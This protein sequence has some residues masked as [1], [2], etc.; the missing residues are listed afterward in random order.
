MYY[1]SS[2][3]HSVWKVFC[4]LIEGQEREGLQRFGGV[5][6]GIGARCETRWAGRGDRRHTMLSSPRHTGL[7][8]NWFSGSEKEQVIGLGGGGKLVP[9]ITT[10][11]PMLQME[12]TCFYNFNLNCQFIS[13]GIRRLFLATTPTLRADSLSPIFCSIT[14]HKATAVRV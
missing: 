1:N 13:K 10:L 14:S 7:I 11:I 2:R 8:L 4:Q 6:S 9:R 5:W 12:E 3:N